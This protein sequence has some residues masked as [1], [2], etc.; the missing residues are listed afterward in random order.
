MA[1]FLLIFFCYLFSETFFNIKVFIVYLYAMELEEKSQKERTLRIQIAKVALRAFVKQ[2]IRAVTMDEIASQMG[3]SKRTLYEL[4]PDKE[5]L[6]VACIEVHHEQHSAEL[7]KVVSQHDNVIDI[8]LSFYRYTV[9]EFYRVSPL[10]LLDSRR[11]P[12]VQ[13]KLKEEKRNNA[14]NTISFFKRGVE[15]GLL[16]KDVNFEIAHELLDHQFSLLMQSN[17]SEKYSF[18]EVYE[19]IFFTFL[20]GVATEKGQL[21][22]EKFVKEFRK[23]EKNK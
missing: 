14:C 15:E 13:K 8:I 18:L 2:G 6:V 9:E 3:I 17:L 22:V 7:K 11:Y 23:N 10:F 4:F 20:R 1:V 12:S 5:T 19:S 16:R 21:M